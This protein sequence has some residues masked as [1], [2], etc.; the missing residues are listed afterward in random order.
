MH[1]P[2][3]SRGPHP[4]FPEFGPDHWPL[5]KPHEALE[6]FEMAK[7]MLIDTTVLAETKFLAVGGMK[8]MGCL[9]RIKKAQGRTV[10]APPVEGRG[11]STLTK[12]QLQYLFWNQMH[13][14]PADDYG[15]LCQALLNIALLLPVDATPLEDL[16]REVA[17]LYP[18]DPTVSTSTPA[19]ASEP[20]V[21]RA[22]GE[23]PKAA[24]TTGKVWE[25]ADRFF[26]DDGDWKTMRGKIMAAC[27]AEGINSATAATQYS[28]WKVSKLAAK[29][30]A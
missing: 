18:D 22:P 2:Y 10:I 3:P 29:A 26:T 23:R 14:P 13:Q 8:E 7:Y 9:G 28:K 15:V 11:F 24:S 1:G 6:V 4:M 19:Q 17:R 16:E 25:I 12:E 21:P 20:R 5:P 30:T 27:E